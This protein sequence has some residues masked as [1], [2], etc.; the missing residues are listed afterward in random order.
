MVAACPRRQR[1]G[2][3]PQAACR[4][5]NPAH[6]QIYDDDDGDD[7]KQAAQPDCQHLRDHAVRTARRER[8]R[9]RQ[10]QIRRLLDEG[11]RKLVDRPIRTAHHRHLPRDLHQP[12][13]V[14]QHVDER[15][16]KKHRQMPSARPRP[17]QK[18]REQ[19]QVDD[20]RGDR[21]EVMEVGACQARQE[22]RHPPTPG[23][24]RTAPVR[25][26]ATRTV[27]VALAYRAEDAPRVQKRHHHRERR[28]RV[29]TDLG[30]LDGKIRGERHEERERQA[31]LPSEITA[32]M[33]QAQR[34]E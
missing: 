20:E 12:R 21:R 26:A 16:G 33:C 11:E 13:R 4:R 2:G 29:H 19:Q 5:A 6:R 34:G 7:K 22:Q 32:D 17:R 24:A 3:T 30:A 23:N 9:C 31:R 28:P 10:E 8:H 15:T 18:I 27:P 25:F 1:G 14:E